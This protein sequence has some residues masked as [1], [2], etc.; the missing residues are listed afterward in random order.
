MYLTAE[1]KLLFNLVYVRKVSDYQALSGIFGV[2]GTLYHYDEIRDI[3]RRHTAEILPDFCTSCLTYFGDTVSG[4]VR[5]GCPNCKV[6]MTTGSLLH[7]Q[8][9]AWSIIT[10]DT[11]DYTL[12]HAYKEFMK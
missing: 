9:T 3:N 7:E 4:R 1:H 2:G 11:T 6:A 12:C 10:Q 5:Q 8:D